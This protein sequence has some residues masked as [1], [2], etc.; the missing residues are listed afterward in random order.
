MNKTFWNGKRVL[1]TGNTG[2]KGSWLSRILLNTGAEVYG[3]ALE[4]NCAEGIFNA[5]GL[6]KQMEC[7]FGDICDYEKLRLF[8]EK[9]KPEVVFHLAAQ[10]IVR[11]SY[12]SPVYTYQTNVMGTVTLLDCLRKNENLRAVVNVTTDKVYANDDKTAFF[13]ENDRLGGYDPYS[14]SKACSEL[15]TASYVSS[16]FNPDKYGLEHNAA[17]ATARAGNVIGGGDYAP[18]RLIPDCMRAVKNGT[19]VILRNPDSIRPWQ[20]VL[21]PISVY[22]TLAEKLYNDGTAYSGAWNIGPEKEDCLRVA[23]VIQ[24]LKE[25]IPELKVELKANRDNEAHEAQLLTLNSYKIK[26]ELDFHS[27]WKIDDA[28]KYTALWYAEQFKG[29][30]MSAITD[31][32]ITEYYSV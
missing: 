23:D 1:V 24:K 26:A 17:I 32:I 12:L 3:Y 7:C 14:T 15:V 2:F 31:K 28:V 8:I 18:D 27:R 6:E 19:S 25:Y 20:N 30:D 10:P 22:I 5:V 21:E 11:E 13:S 29:A 9:V 4:N 16:F